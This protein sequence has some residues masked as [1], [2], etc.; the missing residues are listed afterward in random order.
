MERRISN[1]QVDDKNMMKRLDTDLWIIICVTTAVFVL[2]IM[3]QGS[4]ND[5]IANYDIHVLYRTLGVAA[6]QFGVAGLG[7]SIVMFYRRE[8]FKHYGLVRANLSKVLLLSVAVFIPYIIYILW[9]GQ[10]AGYRPL[11]IMI[12]DEVL[13]SG[14]P[15]NF[16]GISVILIVWGFFE[17]FNY[18]VISNKINAR[19]PSKHRFLNWGAVGCT[20]MCVLIHGVIGVTAD[21][22]FELISVVIIIYG[23]LLIRDRYDNSWG[24]IL[25]FVLLWNAF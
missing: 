23:M 10:F 9:S 8:G 15:T 17:G 4:L 12:S 21:A 11:S 24:V 16:L 20:I 13:A 3:N 19:Y 6:F 14:F 5:F 1:I 7:I 22:L 25:I 18:V 2:L